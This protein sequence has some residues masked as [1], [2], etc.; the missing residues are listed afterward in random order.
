MDIPDRPPP[1]GIISHKCGKIVIT[2]DPTISFTD[3]I[4]FPRETIYN[5]RCFVTFFKMKQ[6]PHESQILNKN[7]PEK[8]QILSDFKQK[9][10]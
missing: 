3:I 5:L 8:S 7:R 4:H 1:Q 6:L 9:I 2:K 10:L